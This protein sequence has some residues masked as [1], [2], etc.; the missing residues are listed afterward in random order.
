MAKRI[1]KPG[2]LFIAPAEINTIATDLF[3]EN[4]RGHLPEFFGMSYSQLH[5]YMTIHN[6]QSVPK[7]FAIALAALKALKANDIPF[8]EMDSYLVPIDKAEPLK[9]VA[10]KKERPVKLDAPEPDFDFGE[11]VEAEPAPE[12]AKEAPPAAEP[13]KAEEPAPEPAKT[14]R[15]ATPK[16]EKATKAKAPAKKTESKAKGPSKSKAG[17]KNPAPEKAPAKRSRKAKPDEQQAAA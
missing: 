4:W 3:G 2:M 17:T 9:F 1:A 7:T 11:E 6:G 13:V 10:E 15:K 5:R 14:P 16:P 8:P 12:P